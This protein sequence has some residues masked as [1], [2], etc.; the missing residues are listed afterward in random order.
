MLSKL[1]VSKSTNPL[2]ATE[3]YG[4]FKK[5]IYRRG[6]PHICRSKEMAVDSFTNYCIDHSVTFY[7]LNLGLKIIYVYATR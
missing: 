3:T 5:Y 2:P 1:C 4:I 6:E 7:N